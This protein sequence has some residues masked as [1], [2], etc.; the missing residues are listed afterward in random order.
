VP[1]NLIRKACT[2]GL[3]CDTEVGE[4]AV[5]LVLVAGVGLETLALAIVPQLERVV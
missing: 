5:F 1:Q 2:H 4:D 3:T